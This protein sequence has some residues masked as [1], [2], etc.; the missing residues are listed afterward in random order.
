MSTSKILTQIQSLINLGSTLETAVEATI[1]GADVAF[2]QR[3]IDRQ[4]SKNQAKPKRKNNSRSSSRRASKKS[5]YAKMQSVLAWATVELV[6]RVN[7][8]A[9]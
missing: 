7:G 5:N 1:P 3:L 6:E 8:G 2:W 9:E 4:A